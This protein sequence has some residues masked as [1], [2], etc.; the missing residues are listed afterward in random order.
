MGGKERKVGEMNKN[1]DKISQICNR[2][3]VPF[4]GF[5]RAV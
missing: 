4:W 5:L 3:L 1:E 2:F